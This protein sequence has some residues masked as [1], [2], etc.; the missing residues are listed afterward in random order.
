MPISS[1]AI[2]HPST[3]DPS[4]PIS[5]RY[6]IERRGLTA[7]PPINSAIGIDS[8]ANVTLL[9]EDRVQI[10]GGIHRGRCREVGGSGFERLDQLPLLVD[11]HSY[12]DHVVSIL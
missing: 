6:S 1:A 5:W 10:R 7:S 11:F 12:K 8:L 3:V 2:T 9:G 4:A